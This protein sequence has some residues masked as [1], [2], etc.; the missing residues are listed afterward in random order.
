MSLK[1][2]G[3]ESA[4][5]PTIPDENEILDHVQ[6]SQA[7]PSQAK[8]PQKQKQNL[9]RVDQSQMDALRTCPKMGPQTWQPQ[10]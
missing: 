1:F 10:F 5:L 3:K 7:T 4:V 2:G 8:I 9:R 6:E